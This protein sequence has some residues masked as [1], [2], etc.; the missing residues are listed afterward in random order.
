MKTI[1]LTAVVAG[2]ALFAS[3]TSSVAQDKSV[4]HAAMHAEHTTHRVVRHASNSTHHAAMHAEHVTHRVVRHASN[5]TH[6]AAMHAE[7]TTH[8]AA[9]HAE[10]WLDHH[11]SA[12]H[13]GNSTGG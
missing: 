2:I 9:V 6:H 10:H 1:S 12:P 13:K 5:T 11:L 4:H 8:K 3:A 7:H